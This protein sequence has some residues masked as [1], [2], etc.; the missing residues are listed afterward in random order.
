MFTDPNMKARART[1]T[2]APRTSNG[3]AKNLKY[4]NLSNM[5]E[6]AADLDVLYS[7]RE[8]LVDTSH[9]HYRNFV[10][11]AVELKHPYTLDETEMETAGPALSAVIKH[12]G[13]VKR[14]SE[15]QLC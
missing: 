6:V 3:T 2:K 9:T 11:P 12:F 15:T 10:H 5:I 7:K 8:S 13:L 14:G 1:S 4:W